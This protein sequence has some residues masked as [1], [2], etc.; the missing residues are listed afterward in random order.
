MALVKQEKKEE[1]TE[2]DSWLKKW[3]DPKEEI[4]GEEE[5]LKPDLPK[6]ESDDATKRK[7]L[8][9]TKKRANIREKC[10]TT[11]S[12]SLKDKLDRATVSKRVDNLCEYQCPKCDKTCVT[13]E[14]IRFHLMKTHHIP[15]LNLSLNGMNQYLLK[16]VAHQC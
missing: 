11:I 6:S 9:K 16:I 10:E 7:I 5:E 1:D 15:K 2:C 14:S 12:L 8:I 13:R 3:A 4:K